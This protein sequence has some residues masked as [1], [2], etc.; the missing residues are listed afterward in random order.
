[1]TS[2]TLPALLP[3]RLRRAS[4]TK[5]QTH[6]NLSV[7]VFPPPYNIKICHAP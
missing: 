6:H 3:T 2:T 7:C 1:L 4:A 5:L